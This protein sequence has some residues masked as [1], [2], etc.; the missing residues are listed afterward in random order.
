MHAIPSNCTPSTPRLRDRHAHRGIATEMDPLHTY[1][2]R[3]PLT[4]RSGLISA[5]F[6]C[7]A[8]IELTLLGLT[9]T[10]AA[11]AFR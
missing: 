9:P 3:R 4:E 2:R 1:R 11:D 6:A 7:V 5:A 8:L 10:S